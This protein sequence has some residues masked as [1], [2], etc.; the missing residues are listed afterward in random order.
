GSAPSPSTAARFEQ[1]AEPRVGRRRR[2]DD[3][4]SPR[5]PATP[6][7]DA[8]AAEPPMA[9]RSRHGHA[10][11]LPADLGANAVSDDVGGRR[12]SG[13][14]LAGNESTG[15]HAR[16]QPE[17]DAGAHASGKSVSEL[18]AALGGAESGGRRRRRNTP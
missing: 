1:D 7:S 2:P 3:R 8:P 10:D 16:Q 14:S 17:Q 4:P 5:W 13:H 6:S 12:A 9:R 18:L 15:S 11:R